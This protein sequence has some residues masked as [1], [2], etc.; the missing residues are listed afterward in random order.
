Q[1]SGA[2]S[3]YRYTELAFA[4]LGGMATLAGTPIF[5]SSFFPGKRP[6]TDARRAALGRRHAGM[7]LLS[8]GGVCAVGAGI[9]FALAADDS[10]Q[11][12][13]DAYFYTG[14]GSAA[15]AGVLTLTGIP[16]LA[17][18]FFLEPKVRVSISPN[19]V[20]PGAQLSMTFP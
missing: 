13:R 10:R 12:N 8:L 4:G 19:V 3:T 7:A 6:L 1:V 18:S 16:V 5:I 14:V 15:V 20:T 9:F 11:P 2:N 17:T